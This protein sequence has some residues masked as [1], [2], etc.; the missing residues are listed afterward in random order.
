MIGLAWD[1]SHTCIPGDSLL[2][3]LLPLRWLGFRVANT[4]WL[5]R[6]QEV[7]QSAW[8]AQGSPRGL[9]GSQGPSSCGE[10]LRRI[11]RCFHSL[12]CSRPGGHVPSISRMACAVDAARV[13]VGSWLAEVPRQHAPVFLHFRGHYPT[14]GARL[15]TNCCSLPKTLPSKL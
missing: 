1:E 13:S 7:S 12:R 11:S 15:F 2:L 5:T 14:P 9:T 8:M 3:F 4:K 10:E 6:S